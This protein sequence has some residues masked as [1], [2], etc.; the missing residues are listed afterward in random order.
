MAE[1]PEEDLINY[2]FA[3][4]DGN[5]TAPHFIK[6][7]LNASTLHT[8][9]QAGTYQIRVMATDRQGDS[10]ERS[11]YLTITVIANNKPNVPMNLLG[12]SSSYTGVEHSYFTMAKDPDDDRVRYTFDWGDGT[13]STTDQVKSGSIESAPHMWRSAGTYH[14]QAVAMDSK[15]A[16]SGQARS[17]DITIAN[18]DPPHIPAIPSGPKAGE[19]MGALKY[20]TYADDPD[21]DQVKYVFDW[22]DGTTSWTGLD[23]IDSGTSASVFHQWSR[24]G[25]YRVKAMAIDDKGAASEWSKEL[26]VDIS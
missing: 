2:T 10:S 3:W 4:D 24:A 16:A 20:S 5:A 17:F 11:D 15:G 1:H 7:G 25:T 12:S 9:S 13:I 21:G 23:F 6:S 18:N 26:V 19:I 22:G 8:L 14:V